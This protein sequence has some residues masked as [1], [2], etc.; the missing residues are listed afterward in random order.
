MEEAEGLGVRASNLVPDVEF[1][2]GSGS[3]PRYWCATQKKVHFQ[4]LTVP[5]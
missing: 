2:N 5:T 4:H 1:A 3:R